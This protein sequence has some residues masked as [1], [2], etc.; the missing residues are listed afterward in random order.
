MG[1]LLFT[2]LLPTSA[3]V[4][5]NFESDDYGVIL[6]ERECGCPIGELGFERHLHTIRSYEKLTSEG[7]NFVGGDLLRLVEE[8]LPSRF[9][10]G[11]PDYQLVEEEVDGLAEGERRTSARGSATSTRRRSSRRFSRRSGRGLRTRT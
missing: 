4:L 7:M 1:A 11:P 8:V 10:G 9:G 6:T 5:L 3:K 2:T